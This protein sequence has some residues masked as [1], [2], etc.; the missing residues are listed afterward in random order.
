MRQELRTGPRVGRMFPVDNFRLPPVVVA[1]AAVSSIPFLAIWHAQLGHEFSSRVQHL[2][3][4]GLLG[5]V[6]TE[7]FDCVSC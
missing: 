5:L 3:S 6:S 1:A 4:R 2:A 7:N